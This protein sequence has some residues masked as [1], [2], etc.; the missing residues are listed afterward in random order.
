MWNPYDKMAD[1]LFFIDNAKDSLAR[2]YCK[3]E[4]GVPLKFNDDGG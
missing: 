2:G 3:S 1:V 4:W